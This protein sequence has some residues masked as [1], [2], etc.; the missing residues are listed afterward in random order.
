MSERLPQD[1]DV[2]IKGH[3]LVL[4]NATFDSA[5][6]YIC[7]ISTPLL[8]GLQVSGSTFIVVEGES[9]HHTTQPLNCHTT[10]EKRVIGDSIMGFGVLEARLQVRSD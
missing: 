5:G 6:E 7:E 1:G 3:T 9:P 8:S 2:V 4:D 10:S